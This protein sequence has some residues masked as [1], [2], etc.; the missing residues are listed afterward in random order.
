MNAAAGDHLDQTLNDM[1]PS[2]IDAALR[3]L[4]G[5]G[6][7]EIGLDEHGHRNFVN[8][9]S[10]ICALVA[11]CTKRGDDE[12]LVAGHRRM[13]FEQFAH[14]V[15]GV[16]HALREQYGLRVG[17]RVGILAPNSV[18][19]LLAAFG[20]ACAGGIA[21]AL[22]SWSSPREQAL[23]IEDAQLTI[24][25]VEESLAA[26][27]IISDLG[28]SS[29]RQVLVCGDPTRFLGK[30]PV[31]SFEDLEQP[32]PDPP[33]H[34]AHE[35]DTFVIV[36]TSGTTGVPKGCITTHRG[37][38]AQ[39]NS[40][41]LSGILDRRMRG[42][43]APRRA[44]QQPALLLTLPLFHV[45]GLHAAVCLSLVT[46]AKVVLLEGR[47]EPDKVLTL[48]ENERITAWGGVP[49]MLQRVVT[50]AGAARADLSSLKNV[51]VGGAPV[52]SGALAKAQDLL[53]DSANVASGYG[54][55]ETHGAITISGQWIGPDRRSSVGRIS[56]I[57]D[58][59]VTDDDGRLIP[60][61]QVGEIRVSGPVVT[62]GYWNRP[63]ETADAI[64]AGWFRTGD[65]GYLDDD[66]YLY[67]VDRS[68]DM[69]IRGGENIYCSEIEH[70]LEDL[71]GV[72]EAAVF[73]IPD[74]DL[75]ERVWAV[76]HA[77][78]TAPSPAQMRKHAT[79]TLAQFKVPDHIEAVAEPLPRNASGKLLKRE[80]RET[81]YTAS[82][83]DAVSH[84]ASAKTAGTKQITESN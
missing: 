80:L 68:K 15:W 21:V 2:S 44:A 40:V 3:E 27:L 71:P 18:D 8:R 38:I 37:T 76:V 42:K 47:F 67:V 25:V 12:F 81:V 16:A 1:T 48:I 43:A 65:L 13:S 9:P 45:S 60:A 24:L 84:V 32:T 20:T 26:S 23:A 72:I 29:L 17:D 62:P 55:T 70:V 31:A 83:R 56:P 59:V 69:I 79:D 34:V 36:Y 6:R 73:G 78:A 61:G 11:Q 52:S 74:A 82:R 50:S 41:I 46:G 35:D 49:T 58:V 5:S 33:G 7:F 54:M 64:H 14:S 22:N 10:S 51:S 53:G 28:A 57:V 77:D 66:G 39:I 63:D 4:T 75:G 30:L 19:W